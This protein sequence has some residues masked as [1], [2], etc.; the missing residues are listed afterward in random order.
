MN[1][2]KRRQRRENIANMV[3]GGASPAETARVFGVSVGTVKTSCREFN[4]PAMTI[5]SSIRRW[6]ILKEL[7]DGKSAREI[8]AQLHITKQAVSYVKITA[9]KA[10]IEIGDNDE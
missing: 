8:Q 4:V 2:E 3:A 5:H 7:I 9:Q 6:K 10:G 1:H